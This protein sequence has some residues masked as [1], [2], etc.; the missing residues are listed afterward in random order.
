M[1][2]VGVLVEPRKLENTE[3]LI[4]NFFD[5]LK[6]NSLYFFCGKDCYHYYKEIYSNNNKIILINLNTNNLTPDEYNDLFK[7]IKFWDQIDT[8]Y[9]LTIQTDGCLCK[10][11]DYKLTDF[12]KYDYIGG[13][14]KNAWR[15]CNKYISNYSD[16]YQCLNGGFS[17]RN[18]K[19]VKDVLKQ[20][21]PK[22]LPPD[23]IANSSKKQ[24]HFSFEY[25]PEDMYF[26][27]GMYK[28]NYNVALDKFA[29]NFCTHGNLPFAKTFCIHNYHRAGGRHIKIYDISNVVTY[30]QDEAW[31]QRLNKLFE[32][33]PDYKNFV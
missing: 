15:Q 30:I 6:N 28:L 33:C 23:I 21:P 24:A 7:N 29:T 10:N 27:I 31:K 1:K 22:K 12:L 8:D 32:Y 2:I 13:C 16:K 4:N 26:S 19:A 25:W 5:I 17:L 9:F 14:K 20:F 3:L 18:L 11:S